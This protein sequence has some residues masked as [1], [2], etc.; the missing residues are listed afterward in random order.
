MSNGEDKLNQAIAQLR[1]QAKAEPVE[2]EEIPEQDDS[3]EIEVKSDTKTSNDTATTLDDDPKPRRSEYV[4]TDDPKIQERI[5]D[6]Y[7]QTKK[8]DARNQMIMQQNEALEK[9]LSETLDRLDKY[10]RMQKKEASERVEKELRSKMKEARENGDFDSADKINE[11]LIALQIERRIPEQQPEKQPAKQQP[12][13]YSKEQAEQDAY[14]E[15]LASEK[16]D[17]GNIIRAYLYDWHPDNKKASEL[18]VSIQGELTAAG[19]QPDVYTIFSVL[20]ERMRGKPKKASAQVLG[21][22]D[23]IPAKKTVKLTGDQIRVAHKMGISPEAYARQ[24][25]MINR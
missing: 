2:V 7:G 17:K 9:K 11:D 24:L 10:E 12:P 14:I 6:L 8:S 20:D 19:K 13:K 3:I 25:S 4:K 21:S 22:G 18:A 16:D 5:N 1:S 23:D 15:Y